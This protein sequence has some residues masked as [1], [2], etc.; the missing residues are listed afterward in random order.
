MARE[1]VL[2]LGRVSSECVLVLGAGSQ[3][4]LIALMLVG[5]A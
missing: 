1:P 2:Y 5:D 3:G 4:T